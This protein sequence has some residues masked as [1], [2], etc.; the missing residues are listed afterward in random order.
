MKWKEGHYG[1]RITKRCKL[2]C[3]WRERLRWTRAALRQLQSS[4]SGYDKGMIYKGNRLVSGAR[5]A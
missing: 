3:R 2:E 5:T 1:G 4:L